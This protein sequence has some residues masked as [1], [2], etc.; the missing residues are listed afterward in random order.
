MVDAADVG[1]DLNDR[2][3]FLVAVPVYIPQPK[4]GSSLRQID[5]QVALNPESE[6]EAPSF[7]K[8]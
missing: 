6:F 7:P 4:Q 2:L 5:T 3:L 8:P 1:A